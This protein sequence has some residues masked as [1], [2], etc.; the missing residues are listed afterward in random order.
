MT[1][2]SGPA[3]VALGGG[4]G[5]AASLRALR[6]LT[7]QLTAV[8]TVADD[9][10]SSGRLRRDLDALPPGDLRMALAALAGD[11]EW[12][13]T[14][15]KLFQYR[16]DAG[17]LSGHAVGNLVL[18][19]LTAVLGSELAALDQCAQLLGVR[20]R[21]LPMTTERIEIVAQ[22]A[23][24][25][26]AGEITEVRGQHEV[27][28]APGR[29]CTVEL[30]PAAPSACQDAVA[31]VHAAEFVVLGPGSLFTSVLPHLLV[32]EL[33][34]AIVKT[35]AT[36]ILSLNLSPQTGETS[37]FSPEA[38]L[39]ALRAHVPDL[40]LDHVIADTSVLDRDGLMATAAE[41]GAVV[42][43]TEVASRIDPARHDP[44]LLAAAYGDIIGHRDIP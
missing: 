33:R 25:G 7:E 15:A 38:H 29:V 28:T 8:V 44:V 5:L 6:T 30:V 42:R 9:G 37:G 23:A 36:V 3:V 26:G 21:V 32:P 35:P 12:G 27:A 4:H 22:V 24:P 11:D 2:S 10:G 34:D 1:A 43:F 17:P 40:R 20:G 19:G 39:E 41:L 31:A 18:V 16:Y 13:R 14:W